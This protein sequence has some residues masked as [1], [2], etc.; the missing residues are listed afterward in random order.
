VIPGNGDEDGERPAV[1]APVSPDALARLLLL[2]PAPID[3]GT[4]VVDIR[5]REAYRRSHI[6]GA[7]SIPRERL[8]RSLFLFPHRERSL[9]LVG[10][11]ASAAAEGTRF[12][13]GRGRA[14]VT[15]LDGSPRDLPRNLLRPGAGVNRA[16]EPTSLLRDFIARLPRTGEAIDL[17]CGSGREAAFLAQHR[18]RVLGVDILADALVQARALARADE[19]LG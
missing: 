3:A 2:E 12:L 1:A 14:R 17:A 5:S 16:W 9:I 15:W 19:I 18:S 7:I 13:A 10:R 4:I 11:D 8:P 6:R